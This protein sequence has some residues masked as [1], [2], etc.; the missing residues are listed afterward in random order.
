MTNIEKIQKALEVLSFSVKVSELVESD[1]PTQNMESSKGYSIDGIY[2]FQDLLPIETLAGESLVPH[3]IVGYDH[4]TS[5][6]F[7]EPDDVEFVQY[8][9]H[10]SFLD[11]IESVIYLL[12]KNHLDNVFCSISIDEEL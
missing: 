9:E 6:G 3:W 4:W 12:V 5:G 11:A 7:W 8:S 1:N 2:L 10:R